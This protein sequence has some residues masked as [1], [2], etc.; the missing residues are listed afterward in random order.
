M[1]RFRLTVSDNY[2]SGDFTIFCDIIDL[3]EELRIVQKTNDKADAASDPK[4]AFRYNDVR[5]R[6]E[7]WSDT[8]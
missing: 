4:I 3:I 6:V 1:I 2:T 8:L 7:A 5:V